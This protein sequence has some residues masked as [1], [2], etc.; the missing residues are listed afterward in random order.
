[1]SCSSYHGVSG[2]CGGLRMRL[3]AVFVYYQQ[4]VDDGFYSSWVFGEDAEGLSGMNQL[5]RV[6]VFE[7]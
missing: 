7:M 6:L 1:V 2:S 5:I 3:W 4:D